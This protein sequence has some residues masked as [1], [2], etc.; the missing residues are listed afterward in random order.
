MKILALDIGDR[1][2]GI[3]ISDPL[4]MIAR[5]YKGVASNT[6]INELRTI[7]ATEPI[8]IVVVGYPKTLRGTESDQTKKI[9]AAFHALEKQFGIVEW[10][11]WDE[12]MTSKQAARIQKPKTKEDKL[13]SHAI[14][15]ALILGSYLDH[16]EFQKEPLE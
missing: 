6:L 7:I 11:L 13:F 8:S 14:A 9:K 3:A 10:V 1:W 12:R 15:A 4:R 16:L 2:T 5:P